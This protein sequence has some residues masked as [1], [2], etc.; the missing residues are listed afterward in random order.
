MAGGAGIPREA[1]PRQRRPLTRTRPH[2]KHGGGK[3]AIVISDFSL[4]RGRLLTAPI[5]PD[6]E[7]PPLA[8]GD[9]KKPQILIFTNFGVEQTIPPYKRRKVD[10]C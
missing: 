7:P 10:I 3:G 5:R 6:F 4:R 9:L 1:A 2:L 8:G